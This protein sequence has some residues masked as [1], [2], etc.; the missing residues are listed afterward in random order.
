MGFYGDVWE[1]WGAKYLRLPSRVIFGQTENGTMTG[2]A[3]LE[4]INS[5]SSNM[6]G[7]SL[8][9]REGYAVNSDQSIK[10]IELTVDSDQSSRRGSLPCAVCCHAA[11]VGRVHQPGHVHHDDVG[12]GDGGHGLHNDDEKEEIGDEFIPTWLVRWEGGRC[13]RWWS[14]SPRWSCR[15]APRSSTRRSPSGE[16]DPLEGGTSTLPGSPAWSASN[17]EASQS[18][19]ADL[20]KDIS[21]KMGCDGKMRRRRRRG[22]AN[23]WRGWINN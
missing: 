12:D 10:Q 23:K 6:I 13:W 18:L 3:V 19:S 7:F 1:C 9:K 11:V 21:L 2:Y 5:K 22:A 16:V 8:P 20:G 15:W 17:M 14:W 4:I